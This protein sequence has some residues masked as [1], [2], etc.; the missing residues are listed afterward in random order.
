MKVYADY[1]HE[2]FFS[3]EKLKNTYWIVRGNPTINKIEIVCIALCIAS[4]KIVWR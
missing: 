2:S 3:S 4:L 1:Y